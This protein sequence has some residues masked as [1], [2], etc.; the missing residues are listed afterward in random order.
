MLRVLRRV[1]VLARGRD[2]RRAGC[3]EGGAP[4]RRGEEGE[5]GSGG[6]RGGVD[7]TRRDAIRARPTQGIRTQIIMITPQ[8]FCR[9]LG[10]H[11]IRAIQP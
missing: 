10:S 2:E 3:R 4:G 7:E 1:A 11:P 8:I 5:E 6:G 9:V